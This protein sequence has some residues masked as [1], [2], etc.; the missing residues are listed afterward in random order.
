MCDDQQRGRQ[1]RRRD[2]AHWRRRD[3]RIRS[4]LPHRLELVAE[5]YGVKWYNDSKATTPESAIASLEALE[6]PVIIIAGGYDKGIAFDELGEKIALNVKAAILMGK[7]AEKIAD[8]IEKESTTENTA[9]K[10]K[11]EIVNSLGE[12]VDSAGQLAVEGD[13]VLLSPACASYDMFD[14]FEHRGQE[15]IRLVREWSG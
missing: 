3:C 14:N 6:Q 12:A 11:V 5:I 8:A 15:F 7:S 10:V 1:T 2:A 4:Q 13:V 9:R